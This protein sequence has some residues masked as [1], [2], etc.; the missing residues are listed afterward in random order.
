MALLA[1]GLLI[2]LGMHSI[3]IVIPE[4]REKRIE[5][6][7]K[8]TWR[9]LY[10]LASLLGFAMIVV[11]FGDA[12]GEEPVW[13][14]PAFMAHVTALLVL[15]AFILVAAAYVPGNRIKPRVG[16]PMLLGVKSWAAGHLLSNGEPRDFLLFGAFLAWAVVDYAASRRRDRAAGV[17]Y[18]AGGPRGDGL[19]VAVGVVGWAVFAFYLHRALIGVSPLG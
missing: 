9:G 4:W 7:G 17:S 13:Q 14:P 12:G 10:S 1:I 18:P 2:F 15:I 5:R 19:T 6:L 3:R 16:H 11:G 8:M